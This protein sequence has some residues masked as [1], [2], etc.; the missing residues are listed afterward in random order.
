MERLSLKIYT[1]IFGDVSEIEAIQGFPYTHPDLLE[2]PDDISFSLSP[3]KKNKK[4][5]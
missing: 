4:K 1:Q 3:A 5:K 2:K